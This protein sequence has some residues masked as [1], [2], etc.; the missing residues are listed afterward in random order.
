M[1]KILPTLTLIGALT[2]STAGLAQQAPTPEEAAKAAAGAAAEQVGQAVGDAAATAAD[3]V[4]EATQGAAEAQTGADTDATQAPADTTEAPSGDSA[5][6]AAAGTPDQANPSAP[7]QQEDPTYTKS[8]HG[9]WQI[10]CLRTEDGNDPC[11]IFQLLKEE[12]GN[13]IA[14]VSIFRIDQEKAEAG[15]TIVVP[16]GTLLPA[17]LKLSVDG[18]RAKSYPYAFCTMIGCYSRIGMS[19]EDISAFKRGA[20]AILTIVPAQAPDQEVDISA[21]LSGFTDAYGGIA[22][23]GN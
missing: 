19:A 18:G 17:E 3:Q 11:H 5:P 22:A 23:I 20:K 10:K 2:A 13:P 21:S 15:A 9:D 4:E 1:P 14:E 8:T 12:N 7:A 16:L 6:Q